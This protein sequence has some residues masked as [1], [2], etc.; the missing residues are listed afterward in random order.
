MRQHGASIED[1]IR[2]LEKAGLDVIAVIV[3]K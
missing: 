3:D 2:P 1:G